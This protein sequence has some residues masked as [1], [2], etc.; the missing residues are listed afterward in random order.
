MKLAFSI[1]IAVGGLVLQIQPADGQGSLTPPGAPGATMLTLSQIEPR[2]PISSAPFT[3]TKPGSYYLTTNLTVSTGDAIDI[4]T[5]GV[6]VDLS[7]F[8]ISSTESSGPVATAIFMNNGARNITIVNGLI[9][10]GITNNGSG[11]YTGFGF[12]NGI[13]YNIASTQPANVLVSHVSVTGCS[14]SG[15]ILGEIDSTAVEFCTVRTVGAYGIRA[16]TIRDSL[17]IDCG[18][19]AIEGLSVM[20]CY[21]SSTGGS[22]VSAE[23]ALNCY[24]ITSSD[25]DALYAE[26]GENSTGYCTGSGTGLEIDSCALNCI[27]VCGNAGDGIYCGSS[28]QNCYGYCIGTGDGISTENAE[29]CYGY[30]GGGGYGVY[31]IGTAAGSYGYCYSGTGLYAFIAS[32]CHGE[33]TTGTNMVTTHNVNSF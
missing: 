1:L 23:N 30:T 25:T 28:A 11:V 9:R 29:N 3:I 5:N 16:L 21:G 20:N 10:S 2:T 33:T 31:A 18:G 24:G 22:G 32:V 14:E 8:T 13:G 27:G 4:D 15:I 12:G 6:T 26:S 7:G 17:A 19:N